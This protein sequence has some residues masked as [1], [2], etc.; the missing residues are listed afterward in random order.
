M[1]RSVEDPSDIERLSALL[2]RQAEISVEREERLAAMVERLAIASPARAA[3]SSADVAVTDT[4]STAQTVSGIG[5]SSRH[6]LPLSTTPAPHLHA[7]ASIREFSAWREKLSAYLMLTGV[8]TLKLKEQRAALLVLLDDEWQRTLRYGLNVSD[9][10]SLENVLDAMEAHLRTQRNVVV[11]R[12]DFY[13]RRQQ[14]GERFDDF[15]CAV[16]EIA[17]FCDFCSHCVD[18]QIRG[19][20]VCGASDDEAVRRLLETKDLT[21]QRAIDICRACENA[22]TTCS[23]I[24]GGPGSDIQRVRAARAVGRAP[25]TRG[26]SLASRPEQRRCQRCG[27]AEHGDPAWCRATD[28]TCLSCGLRG[29]F[30]AM[31]RGD[32]YTQWSAESPHGRSRGRSQDQENHRRRR[33]PSPAVSPPRIQS[34][35]PRRVRRSPPP[36]PRRVRGVIADVYVGRTTRPAP[37]VTVEMHHPAGRNSVRCTPDSGAEATVM[38][39]AASR[40]IGISDADL[41]A[42]SSEGFSAVG[43][44][45]L[46][47]IGSFRADITLGSR[48][49]SVTVFV[50]DQL[51]GM[52]LSWFD[53]VTLGLLPPDFPAQVQSVTLSEPTPPTPPPRRGEDVGR[54]TA[55]PAVSARG[56]S[57]GP[58]PGERRVAPPT[59]PAHSRSTGPLSGARR[60]A[61]PGGPSEHRRLV[62]PG[63][64]A[65]YGVPTWENDD[66]PS[67]AVVEQHRSAIIASFPRVFDGSAKLRAMIGAP[68]QFNLK[69]GYKPVA[70]TAARPIPYAWHEE[71]KTQL[72]DLQARG[73][74]APVDYATEWCHVM[75]LVPKPSGGVRVCVDFTPL[76]AYV[77][78][79][80]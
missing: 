64:V 69:A 77:E 25:G 8:S 38:G 42:G 48:R 13:A 52:L 65:G 61:P 44:H 2:V 66:D 1:A 70:I 50:I 22:R 60:L 17:A 55:L 76:N 3:G 71:V 21:L 57:T 68:M 12:R 10:S 51:E 15:L 78:R 80:V 40:A 53:S 73:I 9:D 4:E 39:A 37:K 59:V 58:P 26:R 23:D 67:A 5:S 41:D 75:V 16:R 79:P 46:E 20:L 56:R 33:S 30:A 43:H 63:P 72:D 47:C 32:S 28:A 34:P 35:S 49:A 18:D 27:R 11:D 19:R 36:S 24:R 29:H 6:R 62:A 45:R 74:I 54:P 7:S 31:C 14:S